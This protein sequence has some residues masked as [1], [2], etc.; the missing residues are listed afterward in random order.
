M[1][2]NGLIYTNLGFIEGLI[3]FI[4][5]GFICPMG[6]GPIWLPIIDG[7]PAMPI[8]P[9]LPIPIPPIPVI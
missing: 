5:A 2:I 4:W 7:G 1:A 3:P 9:I 8:P 6:E